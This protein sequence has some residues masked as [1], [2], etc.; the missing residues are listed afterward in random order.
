MWPGRGAAGL[1]DR[2]GRGVITVGRRE[3]QRRV[4]VALDGAVADAA[5]S[6]AA[7]GVRQSTPTTSAPASAISGSRLPVLDAEVDARHAELAG[8]GEHAGGVRHHVASR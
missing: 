3:D 2:G 7:S 1:D 8:R 6:P 4:E 5:G